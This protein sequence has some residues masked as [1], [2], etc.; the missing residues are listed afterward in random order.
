MLISEL[1]KFRDEVA[2]PAMQRILEKTQILDGYCCINNLSI[3]LLDGRSCGTESVWKAS[4]LKYCDGRVEE[5]TFEKE[6]L[7]AEAFVQAHQDC[8]FLFEGK[9]HIYE[10]LFPMEINTEIGN[11]GQCA[12]IFPELP[13]TKTLHIITDEV[14]LLKMVHIL[15]TQTADGPEKSAN[16]SPEKQMEVN[17]VVLLR[18]RPSE[19][20]F[21][22][23]DFWVDASKTPVI[24][25]FKAAVQDYLNT[26]DGI[27]DIDA[28]C[29]DFNW[30]DAVMY[31]PSET[32]NK[33][34]IYQHIEDI[35]NLT[36]A[37]HD[38]VVLKVNQDE[39]LIPDSYYQAKEGY[40]SLDTALDQAK[41]QASESIR[42]NAT[43]SL[44]DP[45]LEIF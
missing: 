44:A 1:H 41:Q 40:I 38:S 6:D 14:P 26:P 31:V 4:G 27:Q 7:N 34:G 23:D 13:D 18:E 2:Q 24:D 37:R 36:P 10:E 9:L 19:D 22:A 29:E 43:A 17:R 11:I 21:W 20:E 45:D 12:K 16:I 5:Y 30:G 15:D 39:V 35:P 33:H 42:P 32:W 25:L 28:T 3:S 8:V